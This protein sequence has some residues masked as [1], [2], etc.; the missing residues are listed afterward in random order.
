MSEAGFSPW[1]FIREIFVKGQQSGKLC[2]PAIFVSLSWV[3]PR[4]QKRS[5][6][7]WDGRFFV[8]LP[9]QFDLFASP[10]RVEGK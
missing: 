7:T 2:L 10:L 8:P 5:S 3:A 6:H 4:M 1:C 9:Y